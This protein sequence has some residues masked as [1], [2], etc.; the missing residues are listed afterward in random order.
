MVGVDAHRS[1][2]TVGLHQAEA[3]VLAQGL[4][5]HPQQPGGHADQ[6]Q[7]VFGRHTIHRSLLHNPTHKPGL[8]RSE[9]GP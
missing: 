5:V 6:I 7:F 8:P 4:R 3:L 9:Y 2:A 1:H